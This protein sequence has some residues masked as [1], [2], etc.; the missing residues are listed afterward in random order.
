MAGILAAPPLTES[1]L[2]VCQVNDVDI[3]PTGLFGYSISGSAVATIYDGTDDSGVLL[4]DVVPIGTHIFPLSLD[5]YSGSLY[6]VIAGTGNVI[7]Y[8]SR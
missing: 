6:V 2:V 3:P 4:V 8:W 7:I 1:G 5:I